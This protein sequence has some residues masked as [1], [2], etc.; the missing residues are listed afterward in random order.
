VRS[1]P[2]PPSPG[3]HADVGGDLDANKCIETLTLRWMLEQAARAGAAIDLDSSKLTSKPEY[4][5]FC[6]AHGKSINQLNDWVPQAAYS[7]GTAGL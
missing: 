4:I 7:D 5:A 3:F 1:D 2:S 6:N